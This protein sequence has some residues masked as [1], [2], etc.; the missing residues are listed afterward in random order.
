MIVNM[1]F[2]FEWEKGETDDFETH[3]AFA[4]LQKRNENVCIVRESNPGRPRGR[5]A[6]YHWTNDAHKRKSTKKS[7]H[8][9]FSLI[10]KGQRGRE[11]ER[12]QEIIKCFEDSI[13]I[14]VS[15]F[16]HILIE[17]DGN[18]QLTTLI[19]SDEEPCLRFWV[20][21]DIPVLQMMKKGTKDKKKN[22]WTFWYSLK[23]SRLEDFYSNS[24]D[25]K[26]VQK[27]ILAICRLYPFCRDMFLKRQ[28][29][30]F[31]D[32]TNNVH[33]QSWRKVLLPIRKVKTQGC[34]KITGKVVWTRAR[35]LIFFLM[36]CINFW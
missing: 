15:V 5:R 34:H 31:W 2:F 20:R 14:V 13:G 29:E 19:L 10:Q 32:E 12:T 18:V 6:F 17:F 27:V 4:W 26:R 33:R 30:A 8:S 7:L 11:S 23:F 25:R 21:K 9:K 16:V 28:Q 1:I 36:I 3:V 35:A 22:S 24:K